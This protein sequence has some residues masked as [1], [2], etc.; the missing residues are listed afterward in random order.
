VLDSGLSGW[1]QLQARG[2][3]RLGVIWWLLVVGA[4]LGA[5]ELVTL[6]SEAVG[7]SS[8]ERHGGARSK[9]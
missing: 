9:E 5:Q 4:P 3:Q 1:S 7:G 6:S 2:E 8:G